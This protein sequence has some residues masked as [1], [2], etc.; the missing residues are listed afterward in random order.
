MK[1][2]VCANTKQSGARSATAANLACTIRINFCFSIKFDS[3]DNQNGLLAQHG[4]TG[5]FR[6]S[7]NEIQTNI[8]T[9]TVDFE[10]NPPLWEPRAVL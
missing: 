8:Q 2:G 3:V 7:S 6:R 1:Q 10:P 4:G 5:L 9:K